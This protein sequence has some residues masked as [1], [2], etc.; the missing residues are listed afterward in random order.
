M[1]KD[2]YEILGVDRNA[3]KDDIKRAYRQ[4]TKENHPDLHPDDPNA[5]KKMADINEAY[6]M[7]MNPE[8][9][10][11]RQNTNPNSGSSYQQQGYQQNYRQQGNPG[12]NGDFY[13]FGFDDFFGFGPRYQQSYTFNRPQPQ[14]T[15][16]N[17]I[18]SAIDLINR[19][20]Y[21]AASQLLNRMVSSE[22][23]GR[24]YYLSAL[25]QAGI[26]NT[27]QA[28]EYIS[29]AVQMEPDEPEYRRVQSQFGQYGSRYQQT[30]QG[31]TTTAM[32]LDRVCLSL[33]FM[34]LFCRFC[35]I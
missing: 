22:R 2:P 27:M 4:K 24:W 5:N 13:G 33:C 17:E 23:N 11:N 20:A 14:S 26:G 28:Y 16:S 9:Y 34:N 15:D 1:V 10:A 30:R 29:R 25:A 18:R 7:L 3:S 6:D 19:Q 21:Q 31:Y 8:K 12:W 35:G 32:D